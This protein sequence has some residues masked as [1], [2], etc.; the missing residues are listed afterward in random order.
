MNEPQ[1][2]G[3]LFSRRRLIQLGASLFAFVPAARYL[4]AAPD[5]FAGIPECEEVECRLGEVECANY[6]CQTYNHWY[7]IYYCYDAYSGAFCYS[8][9]YNTGEEC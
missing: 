5:V 9:F 1:K 3:K 4:A 2:K 7:D 6:D 8:Y